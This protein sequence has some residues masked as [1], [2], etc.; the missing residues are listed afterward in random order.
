MSMPAESDHAST[1]R[2]TLLGPQRNPRL[3][4]VTESLGLAGARIATITAGWRERES[5]DELLSQ[6][7]GNRSVNLRLWERMQ[8]MWEADPELERA[9]RER[10]RVLTEMQQ[11]Y[12]LGL[13]HA[14]EALSRVRAHQPRDQG[15]HRT[16]IEDLLSI[17]S[18][19]DDRHVRRVAELHAQFYATYQPEH[20][21][22]VVQGRFEVG[23]MVADCDAVVITGG[24][25]GV[26][27]GA[28][29]IFNLAPVLAYP[30][31]EDGADTEVHA[32]VHRPV[33][34]WGAGAMALT[35]R[36]MLFYDDSVVAPGVAEL[37]MEGLGLTRG[38]VALPSATERLELKNTL[39][40]QTLASRCAPMLPLLLDADDQVTLTVDGKV[41]D[42]ARIVGADGIPVRH[43]AP[44]EHSDPG[45]HPPAA[46][47]DR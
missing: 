2:I 45:S 29:H 5:E 28:L 26:L 39:R 31:A 18:D 35:E 14:V 6:Q 3:D 46:G 33:I 12:V 21:D 19:L 7:L 43:R 10:R 44:T 30:V 38:L 27:L 11:L 17:L 34:A 41:P 25:I 16:A 1:P 9:D 8:L 13:E 37:L 42:G 20:R 47:E 15:A 22:A 36:V 32:R 23:R 40:M 4:Q 24:H